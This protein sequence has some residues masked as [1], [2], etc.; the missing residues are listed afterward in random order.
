MRGEYLP[1]AQEQLREEMKGK[2]FVH[3]VRPVSPDIIP[4][5]TKKSGGL[6]R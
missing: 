3:P 4:G 2:S 6:K 1:G 5:A